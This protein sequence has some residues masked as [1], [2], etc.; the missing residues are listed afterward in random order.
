MK[1]PKYCSRCGCYVPE[2][3]GFCP[4]CGSKEDVKAAPKSYDTKNRN[5]VLVREAGQWIE[6]NSAH[7][8][9]V[10]PGTILIETSIDVPNFGVFEKLP[11]DDV[12]RDVVD[13]AERV[14]NLKQF[15]P[16]GKKHIALHKLIDMGYSP[17]KRN[18][19]EIGNMIE[20]IILERKC[21]GDGF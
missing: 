3:L 19:E 9:E 2:V 10:E 4:A 7:S 11:T 17:S 1:L 16:Y 14:G 18:I 12:L 21:H 15:G 5:R 8:I 13:Y 20:E 6:S